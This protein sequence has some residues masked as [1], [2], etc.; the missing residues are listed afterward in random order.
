M[1]HALNICG[2][3]DA[4]LG[5]LMKHTLTKYCRSLASITQTNLDPHYG[6]G[7]S[8]QS[9]MM[10]LDAM[11]NVAAFCQDNDWLLSIDSDVVF[12]SVQLFDWLDVV[13]SFTQNHYTI[14]GIPQQGELAD[15]ELGKLRNMSGCAIFLRGN[16]AKKIAAITPEE[17]ESVREQFKAYVLAE[18]EDILI[19][20]L[21]Q[22][23]GAKPLPI[24]AFMV[25]GDLQ[26]EL[27]YGLP[28]TCMHHLN[29]HP[30]K[31]L[32]VPV[33]GKHDIPIVLRQK[34][35]QL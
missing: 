26:K 31:F 34:G 9:C 2:N 21:A 17:L 23:V 15:C 25:G 33:N 12:T 13:T 6:N 5:Q 10:K 7:A 29:F 35:I 22:M 1:I 19:S 11:R 4:E 32:G 24:P 16:I 8:W 18:Q 3:R 27:A 28:R 30:E 14:V 20:Y